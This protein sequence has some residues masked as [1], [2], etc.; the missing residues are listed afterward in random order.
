[1]SKQYISTNCVSGAHNSDIFD[2]AVVNKYTITVGSD[3]Y[4]RFWD[5][6]LDEIHNPKDHCV[7]HQI[8]PTG[9]HH[10]NTYENTLNLN[11]DHVK[12]VLVG[13]GCFSGYT[14]ISFFVGDDVSGLKEIKVPKELQKSSWTPIFYKDPESKQDYLVVTQMDGGIVLYKLDIT[15]SKDEI[16]IEL[17][18]QTEL[19]TIEGSF[20]ISVDVS[21]VVDGNIAVG[22]TN[23]DVVLYTLETLKVINSFHST[24][25]QTSGNSKTSNAVPRVVTFSPGGSV[26]AVARDNQNS[27]SITLYDVKYGE[28]V[29]TLTKPSHSTSA[30]VGGFA[31]DG[32]IMGLSFDDEGE[33]LGSCGFDKCVRIWNLDDKERVATLN[34]SASDFE[35]T[36]QTEMDS[37]IASGISFISKGTRG[38]SGGDNNHGICV[39]SFD[40]GVRWYRQAGGI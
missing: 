32:W 2:V 16:F 35:D 6:K 8:D 3:G 17:T 4:A 9:I 40:R 38:V 26:L 39:V 37:S 15:G 28:N 23:G 10:I 12:V 29:G 31:H 5:N 11:G 36:D 27:G 21:Q 33:L 18:K 34:L 14:K 19:K 20:P 30:T 1:M 22:Y 24:D 25:L 7:S 13:F